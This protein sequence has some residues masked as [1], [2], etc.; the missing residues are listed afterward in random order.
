MQNIVGQPKLMA[1]LNSYTLQTLPKTLLFIGPAGCGKH[2]ITNYIVNRFKFDFVELDS[3]VSSEEINEFLY[4]TINTLYLIDLDKFTEKQ[5]NQF[6]KFIEEPSKTVYIV[7]IAS[8]EV[9]VLNTILNRCVKHTF[10]PY[11]KAEIEQIT[12]TRVNDLAFEIFKT[13][14]KLL[15]LT[16]DS[17]NAIMDL[18]N[19]VVHETCSTAYANVLALATKINY[20]DI[21]NKVDFNLFFDAVA[22]TAFESFKATNSKHSIRSIYFLFGQRRL[23]G[24]GCHRTLISKSAYPQCRH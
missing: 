24:T 4:K 21:Y 8:S 20:K 1:L 6:L 19:K 17:F 2:T 16:N 22:Y 10:E 5:Q 3:G 18:A 9:G 15:N 7:L 14:G 12:N 13:P 11:S 23:S